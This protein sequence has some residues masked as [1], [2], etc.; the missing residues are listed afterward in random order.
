MDKYDDMLDNSRVKAN[1]TVAIRVKTLARNQARIRDD[2][3]IFPHS[4]SPDK[5]LVVKGLDSS[6]APANASNRR[7]SQSE[8][9]FTFDHVHWSAGDSLM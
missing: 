1:V 2:L 7:G 9:I 3:C 5:S 8:H 4:S 6:K